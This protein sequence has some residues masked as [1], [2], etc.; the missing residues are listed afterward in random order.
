[1]NDKSLSKGLRQFF[2]SIVALT[3]I[4]GLGV[5]KYKNEISTPTDPNDNTDISLQIKKGSTVEEIAKNLEEKGVINC[6]TCF[7]WYLKFNEMD[8][9]IIAGRFLLNK[10]MTIKDI[11]VKLR[12]LMEQYK[13]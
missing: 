1:M 11:S 9:E 3:V 8:R 10:T 5:W 12:K 6:P 7:R 4:F 2:T 13:R